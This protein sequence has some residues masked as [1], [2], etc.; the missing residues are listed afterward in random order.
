MSTRDVVVVG[1]GQAGVQFAV[2]L[3]EA[4]PSQPVVLVGSESGS[5]YQRPQLSKEF[6]LQTDEPTPL[7]LR[8]RE[9]LAERAIDFREACTVT[10]IDPA[11]K[12]VRLDNGA[13]VDYAKLILATGSRKRSLTAP[14]IDLEGVYSLRTLNDALAIRSALALSRRVVVIGAGFIGLEVAAAAKRRG[15]HVTV[16]DVADRPMARVLSK[17]M[18]RFFQDAHSQDGIELRLGQGVRFLEGNQNRVA[19]VMTDDGARLPADLVLVAV[20]IQPNAEIAESAGVETGNGIIVDDCLRTNVSDVWALGDCVNFHHPLVGARVRLESVQNAADQGKY[21]GH[22][23]MHDDP[24]PYQALPW[25]WSYQDTLKLRI[26]GV[27]MKPDEVVV[28][29]DPAARKFST[30]CFRDGR[31]QGVES[32]NATSDHMAAR[33]LLAAGAQLAVTPAELSDPS[34]DLKKYSQG[35]S[36]VAG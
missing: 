23:L 5:P 1:A 4:N 7:V 28:R 9:A 34:F 25:F 12:T 17:P 18:S 14:G 22:N 33:R 24:P 10:A 19:A 21:L 6:M 16:V 13:D 26:A 31:L 11:A 15:L 30:F 29:G 8:T 27:V 3:R 20:G 35:L 36:F 32:L 2:S